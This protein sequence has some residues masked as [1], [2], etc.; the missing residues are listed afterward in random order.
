MDEDCVHDRVRNGWYDYLANL[1]WIVI[2]SPSALA[3]DLKNAALKYNGLHWIMI[4]D[5]N[6]ENNLELQV[7]TSIL[8]EGTVAHNMGLYRIR[9][10]LKTM[11]LK[12]YLP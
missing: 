8:L 7:T 5:P 12:R 4:S 6:W 10:R 3:N 1:N 9:D 11:E 2:S